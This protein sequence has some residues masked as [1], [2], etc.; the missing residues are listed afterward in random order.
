MLALE[1]VRRREEMSEESE[2]RKKQN[3]VNLYC[4]HH[5]I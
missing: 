5:H 3:E 1:C 2:K 4:A